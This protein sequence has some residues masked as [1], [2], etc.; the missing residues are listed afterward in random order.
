MLL[1]LC[2]LL[3]RILRVAVWRWRSDAVMALA[4]VGQDQR[5]DRLDGLIH[6]YGVAA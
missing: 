3:V 2:H 6:E 5:R 1:S 4:I